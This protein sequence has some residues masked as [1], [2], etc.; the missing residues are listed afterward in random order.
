MYYQY[1]LPNYIRDHRD[2]FCKV[3]VSDR[4]SALG[5]LEYISE[6][7]VKHSPRWHHH[8][9]LHSSPGHL[10]LGL[11]QTLLPLNNSTHS[12]VQPLLREREEWAIPRF[13]IGS[14]S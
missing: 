10:D 1:T 7:A 8:L 9:V 12:K 2:M 4:L 14:R 3:F 5:A 11:A 13:G 6:G